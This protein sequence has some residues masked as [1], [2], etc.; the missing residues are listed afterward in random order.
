MIRTSDILP[1]RNASDD[2][3][4][5]EKLKAK[6]HSIKKSR[7]PMFLEYDEF[8]EILKWK[9]RGQ[10]GRQKELRRKN[11]E[12]IIREVTRTA[13]SIE[14]EDEEYETE[15]KIGLLCTLKGV[16]VPVASAV[17][18]LIYPNKYCVIDF[19]GWRQM[20]G[21][22]KDTFLISDYKRYLSEVRRIANEIGWQVQ[23][24]DLAIWE[25]DRRRNGKH[26]N[27]L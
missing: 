8:E 18:A 11:T 19:R 23:E 27:A 25:L 13:L 26:P 5:T 12:V 24:V 10:H 22:R 16:A 1:L 20:F 17:L 15:L 6:F 14:L 7:E 21:E 3:V 2:Y 4:L 9:L